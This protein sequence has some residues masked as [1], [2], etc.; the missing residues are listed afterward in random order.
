MELGAL[1]LHT[2]LTAQYLY[3]CTYTGCNIKIYFNDF[4]HLRRGALRTYKHETVQANG[5]GI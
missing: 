2:S 1:K 3:V 4:R 5:N